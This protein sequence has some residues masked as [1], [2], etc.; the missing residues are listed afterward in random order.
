MCVLDGHGESI[1]PNA[2]VKTIGLENNKQAAAAINQMKYHST[3]CTLYYYTS[4]R[5]ENRI[6]T[7]IR[8]HKMQQPHYKFV[9]WKKT[10]EMKRDERNYQPS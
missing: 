7:H 2:S 9:L 10:N 3:Y 4:R 8:A 6:K 5:R 1:I